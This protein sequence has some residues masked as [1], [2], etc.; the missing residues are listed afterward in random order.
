[1]RGGR[2]LQGGPG[3]PVPTVMGASGANS[4]FSFYKNGRSIFTT[5]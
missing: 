4:P 2:A 5:M 1:L 3:S